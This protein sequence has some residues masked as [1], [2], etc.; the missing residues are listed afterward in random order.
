MK[1]F[2]LVVAGGAAGSLTRYGVGE[3]LNPGHDLPL[4]TLVVNVTAQVTAEA[5]EAELAEAE[6]E[7]GIE[8]EESDEDAAAAEAST[9]AAGEGDADA[10]GGTASEDA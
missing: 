9:E 5:L 10:G 8:R 2:W 7:A 1:L 4:G 6:A 3:W